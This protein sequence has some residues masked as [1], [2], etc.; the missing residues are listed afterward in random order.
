MQKWGILLR[1]YTWQQHVDRR[2]RL[3]GAGYD[4]ALMLM[5]TRII[6]YVYNMYRSLVYRETNYRT[7]IIVISYIVK[8]SFDFTSVGLKF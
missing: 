1:V 2:E 6:I 3:R 8:N 5:W 4:V 7:H